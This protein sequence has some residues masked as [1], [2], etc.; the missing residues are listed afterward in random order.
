MIKTKLKVKGNKRQPACKVLPP[1][2][3]GKAI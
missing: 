1:Y 3:L 2:K